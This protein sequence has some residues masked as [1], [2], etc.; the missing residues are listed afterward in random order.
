MLYA[1]PM[2]GYP[3]GIEVHRCPFIE[4]SEGGSSL[5]LPKN[6]TQC[7]GSGHEPGPLDPETSAL[8]M[9][10]RATDVGFGTR[11]WRPFHWFGGY[12]ELLSWSHVKHSVHRSIKKSAAVLSVKYNA[13]IFK[14]SLVS[15]SKLVSGY[16]HKH[17]IWTCHLW[18]TMAWSSPLLCISHI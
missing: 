9:G 13:L 2:Q 15:N 5:V 7:P 17:P 8:T 3:Y 18:H 1:T 12:W 4:L 10:H 16:L 14:S 11:T 6:T